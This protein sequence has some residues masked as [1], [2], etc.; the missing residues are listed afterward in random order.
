MK[1]RI[2]FLLF[3]LPSIGFSQ[4]GLT[5]F[6]DGYG[7]AMQEHNYEKLVRSIYGNGGIGG[8][9]MDRAIDNL[10]AAFQG[11][12]IS[13]YNYEVLSTV[14]MGNRIFTAMRIQFHVSSPYG[15]QLMMMKL[16][17]IKENGKWYVADAEQCIFT[18]LNSIMPASISNI[19][20]MSTY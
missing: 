8:I 10:R 19:M 7:K 15:S 13:S 12:S 16:A 17:G 18:S 14:K 20:A 11:T 9:G 1:T 3:L 6:M 2:I 5:A 4:N